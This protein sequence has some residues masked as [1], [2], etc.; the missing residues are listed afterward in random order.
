MTP[1][2]RLKIHSAMNGWNPTL[3]CY[4]AGRLPP[5]RTGTLIPT[6]SDKHAAFLRLTDGPVCGRVTF[7]GG[8][9]LSKYQVMCRDMPEPTERWTCIGSVMQDILFEDRIND[10]VV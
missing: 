8:D 3:L 6:L 4:Q 7:P 5:G 9:E 2:L 1:Q 10:V